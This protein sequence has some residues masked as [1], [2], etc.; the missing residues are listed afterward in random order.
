MK[1][2]L[3]IGLWI[4]FQFS[5]SS[6]A[7]DKITLS[8]EFNL[9][10]SK[11]LEGY[12]KPLFT[13]IGESINSNV[14]TT[15]NYKDDWSIGI[16]ISVSGMFIPNGQTTYDAERPDA[17][18]DTTIVKT[19]ELRNGK[20]YRNVV[21]N[22]SQP[23]IFG[24]QSNGI[25]AAPQNHRYPDTSYKSVAYV[26]GNDISFMSG[27]PTIQFIFG[28]PTRT[29]IRFRIIAVPMGDNSVTYWGLTASQNVDRFFNLF[30]PEEKM[31]LSAHFA[32]SAING[33]PSI[34]LSTWNFG[35]HFSKSWNNSLSLYAGFQFEGLK[36]KFEA[37]R[38]TMNMDN[39]V[40]NPF[41]E[42]R[43]GAPLTVNLASFTAFRILG[44]V[45]YKIGPMEIHGDAAWASQPILTFG[46]TFTFGHFG[47]S[48]DDEWDEQW[49]KD[50]LRLK[51]N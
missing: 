15:G 37:V 17:F 44:G 19:A 34:S 7:E 28:F 16:D 39:Y 9:F 21:G 32:Y 4:F 1:Q 29:Q 22:N 38:D 51:E 42:I 25:Y 13:S 43:D 30:K 5:V 46:I 48:K 47:R 24:G 23:T 50:R 3:Y 27:I 20:I 14:F 12:L 33:G 11:N 18:G 26:E 36:G 41:K 35:V 10:T 8:R 40:D 49:E 6:Q 31:G 2:L 45:S